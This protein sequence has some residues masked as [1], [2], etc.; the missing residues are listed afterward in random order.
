MNW[1]TPMHLVVSSSNNTRQVLHQNQRYTNAIPAKITNTAERFCM[2]GS[3]DIR[4]K[5]LSIGP[6]TKGGL[7]KLLTWPLEVGP[8]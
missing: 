5:I 2:N 8:R 7:H 4:L 6:E 3:S 1:D